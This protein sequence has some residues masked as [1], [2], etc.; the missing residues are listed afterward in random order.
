MV[1]CLMVAQVRTI[2]DDKLKIK[3]KSIMTSILPTHTHIQTHADVKLAVKRKKRKLINK[4][5]KV[6]QRTNRK[7]K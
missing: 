4:L 7:K 3:G 2:G 1:C 6:R 5:K